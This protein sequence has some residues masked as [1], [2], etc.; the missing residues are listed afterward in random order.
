MRLIFD[1]TVMELMPTGIAKSTLG[2]YEACLDKQ[3]A[4]D[5]T[6]VHRKPLALSL[7]KEMASKQ[8]GTSMPAKIWRA[9]MLPAYVSSKGRSIVHFPWN[10][11]LPASMHAEVV[12]STIHDVLPLLIPGYFTSDREECTYRRSIQRSIDRSDVVVTVSEYSKKELLKNF[13]LKGEPSVIQNATKIGSCGVSDAGLRRSGY[14]LYVGGYDRRKGLERLLESFIE[15]RGKGLISNDLVL[16]G[17]AMAISP[18]FDRL[19]REAVDR[20]LVSVTGYVSENELRSLYENAT[21]LVYLSK[22]E[23]FGLPP[24]EA[25]TLGCPVITTRGTSIPEVCGEAAYYVNPDDREECSKAL[26]RLETE[27]EL[28][29]KLADAG[30]KRATLFSWDKFAEAFLSLLE[31]SGG[32]GSIE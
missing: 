16:A 20:R 18:G 8:L 5:I 3:P 7:P 31:A 19:L 27:P 10:G 15:L 32:A 12:I 13:R 24:L 1:A 9:V 28:R 21:A 22:Y 11:G 2:L 4:L 23:G 30:R 14:F 6:G 17:E 26:V 25:M 29:R